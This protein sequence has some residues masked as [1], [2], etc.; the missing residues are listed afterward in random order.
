MPKKLTKEEANMLAHFAPMLK[1]LVRA[2]GGADE[3]GLQVLQ[4]LAADIY[5]E[6]FAGKRTQVDFFIFVSMT[7]DIINGIIEQE[8]KEIAKKRIFYQ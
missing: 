5:S 7:I 1:V 4:K 2:R 8:E 6:H 3:E